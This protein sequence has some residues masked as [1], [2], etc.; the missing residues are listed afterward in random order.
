V[1]KVPVVLS[2]LMVLAG[3]VAVGQ[4]PTFR[5]S[6]DLVQVDVVVVDKDGKA[7]RGLKQEDFA[8]HDRGKTQAIATFEEV[9]R[10]PHASAVDVPPMLPSV[11]LDVAD[12]HAG[13]SGR[14]V[15]LVIDDLHIWKGRTDRAKEI[16]RDIIDRLGPQSSMAVLFTSGEHNTT[17]TTDRS[18]LL[19]AV[20]TLKA[21]QSWRRPHPAID[22]QRVPRVDPE[23]DTTARGGVLDRLSDAGK[24]TAQDFFDNMQ[25]YGTLKNAAKMLGAEDVR[26]KAFVL[27]SEGIGKDLSGVFGSMVE[28]ADV[29]QGGAAYA[30]GNLEAFA[31]SSLSNVPPYHTLA[32]LET[33][34]ALRRAN[35]A[36]YAIDPRGA[37]KA[38]DLASECFPAPSP[39]NDPCVDDSAGPNSWMSPV[40]QAQHGLE[41]TATA[42]GGFAV[43]NTDDFTGGLSRI[44][45][46]LDHYYLL[47]FYPT[48]PNGKGFRPL[49]VRIAGHPDWR[50]RYRRGYMG[51]STAATP[52][53][54]RADPMMSLA[55]SIL[56]KSDLPM[57]LTVITAPGASGGSHVTLGLEVSG[58]R[59]LLQESDGRVRD[60][61]KYEV[62]VVDEKK[63][64]V[65]S[66]G[67]LE[68][69]LTLSPKAN[70]ETPPE[71]V[72]YEILHDVDVSPGHFEF[73]VSATSAKLAKG[74]SAY[75]AVD[76][77]DFRSA[78]IVLGSI[79]LGYGDG[80]RVPIAP[81]PSTAAPASLG[82]ATV[83]GRGVG[84][85]PASF[86]PRPRRPLPFPP[87]LDRVFTASD[88][89]RAYVEGAARPGLA[90]LTA[91]IEVIDAGGKT[92]G[93]LAA[94]LAAA[95]P[96]RVTGSLPLRGLSA[97]AYLLRVTVSGGGEKAVRETGFVIR[98]RG[99][100]N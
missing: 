60:T 50:L 36:T 48:D 14:L 82:P 97:G 39:G 73:R 96:L 58:P 100:T 22:N 13:Q 81:P 85:G 66:I 3:G 33:M 45:E 16:A 24:V 37:V 64:K 20:A 57:R 17:V 55:A 44:V 46:D 21:R 27:V 41:E 86:P 83:R 52:A 69:R 89:L 76:V 91:S 71:T 98:D 4:Q 90:G 59:A 92:F 40:R 47:G 38:G 68:G 15:M 26:R 11:R 12:N 31:A 65:R 19:T 32:L 99:T 42:T 79:V 9:G 35:V 94:P 34:E 56:P 61:L 72:V 28:Q 70:G 95:D 5:S 10:E 75:L 43:T 49:N 84:P 62:L 88:T 51:A 80:A 53:V 8:V 77:P 1:L 23:A 78:P 74:G 7:V 54:K 2:V 63:A 93:S 29:P 30:S 25:Q 18:V 87:T 67:G 6:V